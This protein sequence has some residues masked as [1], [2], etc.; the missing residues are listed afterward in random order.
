MCAHSAQSIAHLHMLHCA[1]RS[2]QG[3]RVAD[4]HNKLRGA[5]MKQKHGAC[6][7]NLTHRQPNDHL[8]WCIALSAF[9]STLS[10]GDLDPCGLLN[11][12]PVHCDGGCSVSRATVRRLQTSA[13]DGRFS[14]SDLMQSCTRF[15]NGAGQASLHDGRYPDISFSESLHTFITA[16]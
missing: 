8:L 12:A 1:Q 9:A 7:Q 15:A 3:G 2:G 11:L 14:G 13:A 16:C 6:A 10:G 5:I 4:T